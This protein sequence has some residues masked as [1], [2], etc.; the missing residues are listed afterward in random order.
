MSFETESC[1][2]GVGLEVS[3]V[4]RWTRLVLGLLGLIYIAI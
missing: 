1:G 3:R 4:G 2:F